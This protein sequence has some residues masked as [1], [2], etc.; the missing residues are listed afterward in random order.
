MPSRTAMNRK[1]VPKH[2]RV[3]GLAPDADKLTYACFQLFMQTLVQESYSNSYKRGNTQGI[4]AQDVAAA[5]KRVLPR[6]SLQRLRP[7]R[8]SPAEERARDST[9]SADS[10]MAS[11]E[12]SEP[13]EPQ[14]ISE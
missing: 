2:S 8:G 9:G 5:G 4:S 6:F 13:E 7:Q 10:E 12:D 3:R 11:E 1:L 14:G